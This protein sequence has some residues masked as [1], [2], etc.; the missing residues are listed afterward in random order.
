MSENYGWSLPVDKLTDEDEPIF[1]IQLDGFSEESPVYRLNKYPHQYGI[2]NGADPSLWLQISTNRDEL[3]PYNSDLSRCLWEIDVK[4][5]NTVREKFYGTRLSSAINVKMRLNGVLVSDYNSRDWGYALGK[6]HTNM[7]ECLEHPFDFINAQS[8]VGRKIHYRGL[9][10][11]ISK[12]SSGK[13][14]ELTIHISPRQGDETWWDRLITQETV[15]ANNEE[16][17]EWIK[18][19]LEEWKSVGSIKYGSPIGSENIDWF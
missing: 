11:M 6:V 14:D 16:D 17:R 5:I 15:R 8:E 7:A 4:Q 2:L 19:G 10:A 18:E 3:I 9:P 13:R 12:V 1:S